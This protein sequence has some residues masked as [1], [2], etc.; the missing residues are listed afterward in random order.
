MSV[1]IMLDLRPST[2]LRKSLTMSLPN[3]ENS[4]LDRQRVPPPKKVPLGRSKAAGPNTGRYAD[5]SGQLRCCPRGSTTTHCPLGA[6]NP[7]GSPTRNFKAAWR[8][9]K[10][11]SIVPKLYRIQV[12]ALGRC[13]HITLTHK[14][15]STVIVVD[16]DRW[17]LAGGMIEC[18]NET[19]S[20]KLAVLAAGNAGPS[21]I[22]INPTNGKC[23]LIWLIDP[24]YADGEEM[25]QTFVF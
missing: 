6:Q 23:Q 12:P 20:Q 1:Q 8:K 16:I 4:L 14:Q 22:G 19:V 18:L 11:G 3:T 25:L 9:D 10:D 2:H 5:L 15:R 13:Q 24:L 17:G 7:P 21:W